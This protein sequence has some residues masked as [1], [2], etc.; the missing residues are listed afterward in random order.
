VNL[1]REQQLENERLR[2]LEAEYRRLKKEFAELTLDYTALR[3]ALIGDV[4]G[5]C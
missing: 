3:A 2:S 1:I 4:R 5:D